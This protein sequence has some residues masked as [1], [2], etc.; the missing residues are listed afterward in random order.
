ML[1][2]IH[3]IADICS[4]L[5]NFYKIHYNICFQESR[6]NQLGHWNPSISVSILLSLVKDASFRID[7]SELTIHVAKTHML[8]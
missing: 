1:L 5:Y 7:L 3:G 8:Y 4:K 2:Y 6:E